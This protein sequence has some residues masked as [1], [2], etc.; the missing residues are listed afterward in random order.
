M[1]GCFTI[2]HTII[3]KNVYKITCKYSRRIL[4]FLI[5]VFMHKLNHYPTLTRQQLFFLQNY[6]QNMNI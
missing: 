2:K 6:L 4:K 5:K 1:F 3:T